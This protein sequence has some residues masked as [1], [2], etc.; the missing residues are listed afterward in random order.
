MN[1]T[2]P[3]TPAPTSAERRTFDRIQNSSEQRHLRQTYGVDADAKV[4][5]DQ[6]YKNW[7]SLC[8]RAGHLPYN[9]KCL[10]CGKEQVV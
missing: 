7:Q 8:H 10:R 5:A 2:T 1:K 9:G 3:Q 4:S 6:R